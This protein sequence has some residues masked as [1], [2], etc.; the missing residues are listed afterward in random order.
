MMN[1]G[2]YLDLFQKVLDGIDQKPF[3]QNQLELKVGVWMN[4]VALKI[5]KK[6]W[7]N[8]SP[9]A[10]PFGESIFFSVWIND[11]TIGQGKL[12][13][14]IHA[15]KLHELS[16]YKIKSRDFAD[17]FRLRFKPFEQHWPNVSANFGPLTL[18]E[19]WLQ[20]DDHTLGNNIA[21]LAQKFLVI[22][23]I[24]DTLLTERKK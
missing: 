21:S 12:Y 2:Y 16:A 1:A 11:E 8:Q 19:G 6:G 4:S 24:I 17:A 15:L 14:N 9:S 10:K 3:A 5:Q 18:M 7:L 22:A 13:Y 20:L 23:P